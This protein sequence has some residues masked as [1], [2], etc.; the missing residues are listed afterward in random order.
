MYI[1]FFTSR[2]WGSL[3]LLHFSV[4]N[5]TSAEPQVLICLFLLWNQYTILSTFHAT[6]ANFDIWTQYV[7]FVSYRACAILNSLHLFKSYSWPNQ[8]WRRGDGWLHFRETTPLRGPVSAHRITNG[9]LLILHHP[10][11]CL[12]LIPPMIPE[13]PRELH[14]NPRAHQSRLT[15]S[16]SRTCLGRLLTPGVHT[17]RVCVC[18]CPVTGSAPAAPTAALSPLPQEGLALPPLAGVT[19]LSVHA[20]VSVRQSASEKK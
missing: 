1:K 9:F 17:K 3:T 10:I 8:I 20:H 19:C 4:Q 12:S 16:S 5:A 18:V 11:L 14:L 7:A 15:S 2:N 13:T 6:P